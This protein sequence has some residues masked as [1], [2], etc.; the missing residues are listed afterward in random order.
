[1][2][3]RYNTTD[4]IVGVGMCAIVFGALLLFIAANGTIQAAPPQPVVMEQPAGIEVGMTWLQPALGQA[5]VDQVL[6]GHRSDQVMAQAASEWNRATLAYH[7][8]QSLP[9]GAFGTVMRQAVAVPAEHQARVQGILGRTIVNFTRRGI[10]SGA[11]SADQYVS[12]FNISMIRAAEIRGQHLDQDFL[13]NWQETLGRGIVGAFQTYTNRAEGIQEGLGT[14]VLHVAQAQQSLE[15][16]RAALQPQ[17]ASLLVA[18]IR[19][20]EL[21]G[22]LTL[23]AAIE[24]LPETTAVV[25]TEPA[26]WPEMPIGYLIAAG[27]MLAAVFFGGLSMTARSREDKA[28]SAM[29]RNSAKW[30]YRLA[31]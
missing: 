6:F 8:F 1:M 28:I 31:A 25:S 30:A 27:L 5:I 13:S 24:S 7:E 11:L 14:A 3:Y 15:V 29:Q 9:G 18:A 22:R 19:T 17:L 16:G 21:M 20:D 12:D 26:S 2:S 10:R 4:I 23:L